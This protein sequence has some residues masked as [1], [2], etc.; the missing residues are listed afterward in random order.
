VA[1]LAFC[2]LASCTSGGHTPHITRTPIPPPTDA[3]PAYTLPPVVRGE[4]L[5]APSSLTFRDSGLPGDT[6]DDGRLFVITKRSGSPC[7]VGGTPTVVAHLSNGKVVTL[8]PYGPNASFIAP[9]TGDYSVT[10]RDQAYVIIHT[11][12]GACDAM[13]PPTFGKNAPYFTEF[14]FTFDGGSLDIRDDTNLSAACG[15]TVSQFYE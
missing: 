5:C 3:A 6:A 15:T 2:L 8:P 12:F 4:P 1:F 9:H 7:R 13:G 14:R 10:T 11:Y